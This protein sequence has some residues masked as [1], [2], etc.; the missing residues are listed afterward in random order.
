MLQRIELAGPITG[1]DPG[2]ACEHFA[3]PDELMTCVESD[4]CECVNKV[5]KMRRY[6]ALLVGATET[7]IFDGRGGVCIQG[8]DVQHAAAKMLFRVD[9][10]FSASENK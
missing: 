6:G 3:L 4:W 10:G 7:Y 1:A 8:L 2:R 9:H 5:Q